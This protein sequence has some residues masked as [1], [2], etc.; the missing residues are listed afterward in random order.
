MCGAALGIY[1]LN[2]FTGG[3]ASSLFWL[4]LLASTLGIFG[5]IFARSATRNRNWVSAGFGIGAWIVG[6][7]VFA[8]MELG[9][10]EAKQ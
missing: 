10:W 1:I 4:T 2:E 3:T 8:L 5:L 6:I 9:Y 7:L